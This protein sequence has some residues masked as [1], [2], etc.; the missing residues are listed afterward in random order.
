MQLSEFFLNMNFLHFSK[1]LL[2]PDILCSK[3]SKKGDFKSESL[4]K[5]IGVFTLKYELYAYYF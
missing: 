1:L 4:N 2:F 5:K 3:K